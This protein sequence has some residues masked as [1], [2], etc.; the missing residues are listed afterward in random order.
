[1]SMEKYIP[2]GNPNRSAHILFDC[3]QKTSARN[4]AARCSLPA[5]D[6]IEAELVAACG[7]SSV[8][9]RT[10]FLS[11]RLQR[12]IQGKTDTIPYLAP[13]ITEKILADMPMPDYRYNRRYL[14]LHQHARFRAG[15]V[16]DPAEPGA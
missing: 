3:H 15:D 5:P 8:Y 6:A 1:M 13:D 2:C 9:R 14:F 10:S 11:R 7:W 4:A 12:I 16:A